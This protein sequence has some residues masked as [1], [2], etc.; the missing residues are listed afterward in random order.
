MTSGFVAWLRDANDVHPRFAAIAVSPTG[1]QV[2]TATSCREPVWLWHLQP[3]QTFSPVDDGDRN[4][5]W[6]KLLISDAVPAYRAIWRLTA[7]G[8][9]TVRY[10]SRKLA[11]AETRNELP[12]LKKLVADL[13]HQEFAVRESASEAL[14]ALGPEYHAELQKILA[15]GPSPE[16]KTRI[17]AILKS[18]GAPAGR[19]SG[20]KLRRHRAIQVLEHVG[21]PEAR[22]VLANIT[23]E[24]AADAQA[25][26]GRLDA[27]RRAQ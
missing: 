8:D 3:P 10:V 16:V 2:A 13:D 5:L 12:R 24:H 7:G 15:A 11:A 14:A 23:G 9:E 6:T 26:L 4:E 18:R 21:T 1:K 27:L 20:E 22:K 17:T 25:S 19:L